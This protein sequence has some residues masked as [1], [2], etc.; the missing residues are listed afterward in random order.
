M[1]S[2]FYNEKLAE[3][4]KAMAEAESVLDT[5]RSLFFKKMSKNKDF[6]KYVIEEI[7]DREI[8]ANKEISSNFEIL[9]GKS[10]EEIK[11]AIL[12]KSSALRACEVIKQKILI[13]YDGE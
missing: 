5:K 13:N 1:K 7:L 8:Q 4:E 10:P 12:A 9:L 6:Q 2:V 11:D 3:K